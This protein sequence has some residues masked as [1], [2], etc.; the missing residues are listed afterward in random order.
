MTNA[1]LHVPES[2]E[3]QGIPYS[4]LPVETSHGIVHIDWKHAPA[5]KGRKTIVRSKNRHFGS[6]FKY[7]NT[8]VIDEAERKKR[9]K[10]ELDEKF[11]LPEE[12]NR[13]T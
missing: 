11:G 5:R 2:N 4:D 8:A 12:W 1:E 7:T 13:K 3:T 6:T 10:E 9:E